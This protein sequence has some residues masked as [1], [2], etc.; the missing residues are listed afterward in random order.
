M[1]LIYQSPRSV[2]RN[3]GRETIA[4]RSSYRWSA[5]PW[6]FV[7]GSWSVL[8]SRVL[9]PR[10]RRCHVSTKSQGRRTAATPK[11]KTALGDCLG[12]GYA[13]DDRVGAEAVRGT[14]RDST[15]AAGEVVHIADNFDIGADDTDKRC[16]WSLVG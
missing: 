11:T 1:S 10:S 13:H 14:S 9:G 5:R 8:W 3:A 12:F 2:A 7:L 15:V 16:V 6:S 4:A